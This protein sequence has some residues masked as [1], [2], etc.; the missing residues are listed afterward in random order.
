MLRSLF[1][2]VTGL[3]TQQT[4][5]DVISNNIANSNTTAFKSSRITFNDALSETLSG[6]RGTAGNFGGANPIQ[7]GRGAQISSIDTIF[8]QGSLDETGLVTDLAINGKGFFVLSDGEQNYFSRAGAFQIQKDGSLMAQGGTHYVLGRL[9]DDDGELVST[10]TLEKIQLPFGRKEPAK[11]TENIDLYC[12]LDVNASKVEEWL[13]DAELTVDGE[14]ATASNDLASIDGNA[15]YAG[16]VIE[17]SGKDHEGNRIS[18]SFKYGLDGTKIQDLINKVNTTFNSDDPVNGASLTLDDNGKL[19]LLGNRAGETKISIFM[20][21]SN[22][23]HEA[24]EEIHSSK[25][26]WLKTGPANTATQL[27]SLNEIEN[28]YEVGDTIDVTIGGDTD[29]FTFNSGDETIEDLLNWMNNTA[30]FTS[31]VDIELNSNGQIV[32]NGDGGEVV[33]AENSGDGEGLAGT[34]P[35][36]TIK[37]GYADSSTELNDIMSSDSDITI[38]NYEVGD[39]I[40]ISGT[41][42]D[43][44]SVSSQFEFATGEETVE[45]LL[46]KIN[47]TFTGVTAT[48]ND[49][50]K[51]VMTD[52]S[53]GD[54]KTSITLTDGSDNIGSG[55]ELEFT[56]EN[57]T[58]RTSYSRAA[59]SYAVDHDEINSLSQVTTNYLDNDKIIVDVNGEIKEFVYGAQNDGTTMG[60]IIDW[61]NDDETFEAAGDGVIAKINEDGQI[62]AED[63]AT[64]TIALADDADTDSGVGMAGTGVNYTIEEE[65]A[66]HATTNI[67]DILEIDTNYEDGDSLTITGTTLDGQT[68]NVQFTYGTSNDGITLQDLLDKINSSF[69]GING[70]INSEGKIQITDQDLSDSINYSSFQLFSNEGNTGEGL[71]TGFNTTAGTDKSSILLPSFSNSVIGETGQH[72]T[73]KEVYDSLGNRHLVEITFKQDVNLDTG[74]WSWEAT[75]D[76]GVVTPSAGG[77]GTVYFNEDGSL[78]SFEYAG[79][80]DSLKFNIPG[81]DEMSI[82]LNSGTAGSFD[83]ITQMGSPS[84]TVA[85][86]QDGHS[87]GVLS[88]INVDDQGIVTGIYSNG[89]NK[90]LAQIAMSTFTNE[91]GLTKEG[92]SL[93]AA[94]ESSGDPIIN[95]AG[96]NTSTIIKSGYLESSNVD[97]TDQF[98]KMILSQRALQANAKVVNTADQILTTIINRMKR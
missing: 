90:N 86:K 1:S 67:N 70:E 80:A 66:A 81:A 43:G 62:V 64:Y 73:S 34:S 4:A 10:T 48:I 87:L 89:I 53:I 27:N 38:T 78:K 21:E 63:P 35:T 59:G 45:D 84:T 97:L 74:K 61:I 42:P 92:N 56:T 83:G 28:P 11:A 31:D 82:Q 9:A 7:V 54:S 44:S 8:K 60:D 93:F 22:E 57:F 32:N 65:G 88:N 16:D 76:D 49:E 2:G 69:S 85:I 20:K 29:T 36:Y 98:A 37:L 41:N 91:S 14:P 55:L 79:N 18:T 71:A 24:T 33:I 19:R 12:N 75:I 52:N 3:K 68:T 72:S 96:Q 46:T 17:V 23:N 30:S 40:N 95:W 6:A 39:L 94:N 5:M 51:I 15:I 13:G 25:T 77:S 58:A 50:G 47:D 26:G